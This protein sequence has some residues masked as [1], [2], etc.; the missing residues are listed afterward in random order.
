MTILQNSSTMS[1]REIAQLTGKNHKDVMRAIRNMQP[2][3]LKV[4]G[5]NFTL[6][7]MPDS[8]G[9]KRPVYQ[10][11]RKEC[12]YIATKF[13]DEARA[14]LVIRWEELE[15]DQMDFS[16]PNTV[17]QLAQN[18]ANEQNKRIAAENKIK[19]LAPKAQLMD[20]VMDADEKIDIG[21]AA[22]ILELPFGRNT[23]FKKLRE[24]GVF[25]KNR[26]EPKQEYLNRGYFTLKEKFIDRKNHNGFVIIKVL[27]TQKG[28]HFLSQF[29]GVIKNQNK[30]TLMQ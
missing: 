12:L 6:V 15:K 25:F 20:K 17:L 1:S 27:V 3:W 22:K 30:L 19:Q 16:N 8:K 10:L 2:A 18:W 28:L 13:N 4:N 9:E 23:M 7:N 29:F 5:R 24:Q 11:N 21:Q 14:K 26:N